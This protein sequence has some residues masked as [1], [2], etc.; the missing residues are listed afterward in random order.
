VV[1]L[2][3][4]GLV[5]YILPMPFVFFFVIQT[6]RPKQSCHDIECRTNQV[7]YCQALEDDTSPYKVLYE[8]YQRSHAFHKVAVMVMKVLLVFPVILC[9]STNT[10]GRR[11]EGQLFS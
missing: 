10:F 9:A 6:H 7:Q 1:F 2:A 4:M 8:P 5:I 3:V 11:Q